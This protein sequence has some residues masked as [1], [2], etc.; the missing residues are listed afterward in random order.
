MKVKSLIAI[1]LLFAVTVGAAEGGFPRV[2]TASVPKA[3]GG[4]TAQ[5]DFLKVI[6]V[7][8]NVATIAFLVR[9]QPELER[10][11]KLSPENLEIEPDL[12][13]DLYQQMNYDDGANQQQRQAQDWD[14]IQG[15]SCYK[16]VQGTFDWMSFMVNRAAFKPNLSV[17]IADI[18]NSYLKTQN[19]NNGHDI[20]ALKITGNSGATDKGILFV[21]SGLHA[22]EYAPPELVSRWAESLIGGYGLDAD[23]TAMLDHTEI[24][25][26]LQ[27]NPD[28]REV[29]ETDRPVFQRKNR[30]GSPFLCGDSYGVDLNRNFPFGWGSDEGS[31]N[32]PCSQIYRG[33]EPA[34]E[35]EVRAI[36]SYCQSIFPEGQ[37]KDDPNDVILEG[38]DEQTTKGVFLDVHSSGE[39]IIWPWVSFMRRYAAT[40]CDLQFLVR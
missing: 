34:S 12:T 13:A 25:L 28:G 24:H 6:A 29:A 10:I 23:V 18:G 7:N 31:S 37:G 9:D 17:T 15:F 14:S 36:M 16:S 22:R 35:P 33:P 38:Y 21:M 26:V 32:D 19:S 20:L 30:N 3:G 11:Q 40:K 4:L 1:F 5:V 27:A 2:Y 8:E 39:I